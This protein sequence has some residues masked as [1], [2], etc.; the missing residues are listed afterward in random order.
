MQASTPIVSSLGLKA[1][2]ISLLSGAVAAALGAPAMAQ[3][4]G[5][6]ELDPFVHTVFEPDEET[7]E[8]LVTGVKPI[9]IT[10]GFN[11]VLIAPRFE[12]QT[13]FRLQGFGVSNALTGV[14]LV[15][16]AGKG[17]V[18]VLAAGGTTTI[19]MDT[20]NL[21]ED[22]GQGG[23]S[24]NENPDED[25]GD[26]SGFI[27]LSDES[28][29]DYSD[30]QF[31]AGAMLA[32]AFA[33]GGR[34][35]LETVGRNPQDVLVIAGHL[36][37]TSDVKMS[38]GADGSE[39][40]DVNFHVGP[41]AG[42]VINKSWFLGL[43]E[44]YGA[45]RFGEGTRAVFEK[46]AV[47]IITDGMDDL[48]EPDEFEA[49]DEAQ[50]GPVDER[51]V[52]EAAEGSVVTGVEHLEG[53]LTKDGQ[54]CSMTFE[55]TEGGWRVVEREWR[56]EGPLEEVVNAL[57]V[58]AM[59]ADAPKA[60]RKEFLRR[61]S[62]SEFGK[63]IN[64]M[65]ELM[66]G[67]GTSTEMIRTAENVVEL[68]SRAAVAF[69]DDQAVRVSARTGSSRGRFKSVD[70]S[71][72]GFAEWSRD[73]TGLDLEVHLRHLNRFG[74]LVV[75]YADADVGSS[76]D[77]FDVSQESNIASLA[78]YYGES[79]DRFAVTGYGMFS[80]AN[81]KVRVISTGD[82]L[83]TG[84]PSRRAM[85]AGV[86]GSFYPDWGGYKD[87]N[88]TGAVSLTNYLKSTYG[89]AFDGERVMDVE[90]ESRWVGTL[91]LQAGWHRLF[92]PASSSWIK[93]DVTLGGRV[94]AGDLEV[95][96]TVS[97]GGASSSIGHED[98]TRGEIFGDAALKVRLRDSVAGLHV[99]GS[100]GPD[101]SRSWTGGVSFDYQF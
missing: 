33:N 69:E 56:Y 81:D 3:D 72:G 29:G 88:F 70:G 16:P 8:Y 80:G 23:G 96:Q 101:G 67:A 54:V 75:S 66:V 53:F 63:T 39:E 98:L 15:L 65:T 40:T 4:T 79:S 11:N 31:K 71:T 77:V 38:F 6:I 34:A 64:W 57:G 97:A 5:K 35:V 84:D 90:E 59:K 30:D 85:T 32:H 76:F 1:V 22:D 25:L 46:G 10:A 58:E 50:E 45:I 13:T 86:A 17:P 49:D 44:G 60:L 92:R 36:N 99:G 27:R 9:T 2:R 78:V 28:Q 37:V 91:Q 41:S 7:R 94:R 18:N 68:T 100:T 14:S 42:I 26:L 19:V 87:V 61:Q 21:P 62:P 24:G 74:G 95:R 51:L 20:T 48:R 47:F 55:Q 43:A 73:V 52:F 82:M 89:I 12:R 93:A 83:T